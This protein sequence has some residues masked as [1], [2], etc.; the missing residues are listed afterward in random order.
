M[1]ASPRVTAA[2][3]V[4]ALCRRLIRLLPDH[5][6][7]RVATALGRIASPSVGSVNWGD[8]RRVTPIDSN[9]GFGRGTPVDRYYIEA[10]LEQY[11]SDISGRALEIGDD[12]YCRRF[13]AGRVS[14]QD[15]FHISP[16]ANG[17]TIVGDLSQSGS[18]PPS[19]F[20][21]MVLT[22]TLHLI[23]DLESAVSEIY[24]ALKPGGVALVTVPGISPVDRG[25]WGASW[26]WSLTDQ[27]VRRLFQKD[28]GMEN[29]TVNAVGNVYAATA[30]LQ[31]LALEE[32]DRQML[33]LIDTA[34]PLVVTV[35]ARRPSAAHSEEIH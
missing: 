9:F 2:H 22:Q 21:C 33:H 26:Y 17:V 14:R 8:L 27:A 34:F 3:S 29:I 12:A 19:A 20:D 30:F 31:G 35:R 28:F 24:R 6:I 25:E 10:F 23:Y 32:V 4:R 5:V 18:L 16:S 7:N 1:A 15:I 13:G 11:A